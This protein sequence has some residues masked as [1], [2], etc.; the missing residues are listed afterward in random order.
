MYGLDAE[1]SSAAP[2]WPAHLHQN[3]RRMDAAVSWLFSPEGP[4][5]MSEGASS[6]QPNAMEWRSSAS[7]RCFS[8]VWIHSPKPRC[9]CCHGVWVGSVP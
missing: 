5:S 4:A 3:L 6:A 7:F 9:D 2:E 8:A 1:V